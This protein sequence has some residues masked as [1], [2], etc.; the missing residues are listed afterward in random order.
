MYNML[1]IYMYIYTYIVENGMKLPGTAPALNLF[2]DSKS[3]D[4]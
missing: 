3:P 1:H 2:S 4:S